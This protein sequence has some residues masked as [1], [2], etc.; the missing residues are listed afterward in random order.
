MEISYRHRPPTSLTE[1]ALAGLIGRR[2][3]LTRPLTR[4]DL[5]R[6]GAINFVRINV[7][8]PDSLG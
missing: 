3:A 8:R 4:L 6:G 7:A 1:R 5:A 2:P